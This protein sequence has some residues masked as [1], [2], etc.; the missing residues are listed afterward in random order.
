MQIGKS[1]K[2]LRRKQGMSQKK[3]AHL[4]KISQTQL[5]KIEKDINYPKQATFLALAKALNIKPFI[6]IVNAVD[7]NDA[8]QKAQPAF[9]EF[10]QPIKLQILNF[11]END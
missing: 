5:S 2:S 6:I 11:F 9:N 10:W 3:L 4:A 1:I 8:P 7:I